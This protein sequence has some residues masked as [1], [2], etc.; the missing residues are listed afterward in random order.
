MDGS[1]PQSETGGYEL[2]RIWRSSFNSKYDAPLRMVFPPSHRDDPERSRD[3]RAG[4]VCIGMKMEPSE[5]VIR[6]RHGGELSAG[7]HA[8]EPQIDLAAPEAKSR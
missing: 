3:T 5:Y 4:D 6:C 7:Q 8:I 1:R 2:Q